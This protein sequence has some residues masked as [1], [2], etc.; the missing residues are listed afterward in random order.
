MGM[1]GERSADANIAAVIGRK[2]VIKIDV[3][4]RIDII[5]QV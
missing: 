2:T 3:S 4:Q 5:E 1:D